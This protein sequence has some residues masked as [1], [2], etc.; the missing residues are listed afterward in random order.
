MSWIYKSALV[1]ALAPLLLGCHDTSSTDKSNSAL[2]A[3]NM[4]ELQEG[5]N[6]QGRDLFEFGV[7]ADNA[8]KCASLCSDES[9]CKAMSYLSRL[10]PDEGICWLKGSVPEPTPNPST[11]SAVK[12]AAKS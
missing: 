2:T 1:A 9:R 11:V 5:V 8:A 3:S 4:G 6:L 12:L 7:P 10:A